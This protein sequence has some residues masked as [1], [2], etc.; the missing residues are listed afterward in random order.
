M[1]LT[2][3]PKNFEGSWIW[4]SD[5]SNKC[6]L[7]YEFYLKQI[8]M[9][10]DFWFA[11]GEFAHIYVNGMHL[12]YGPHAGN[13]DLYSINY[14][15]ITFL[16]QSGRNNITVLASAPDLSLYSRPKMP[17]GFWAQIL[18]DENEHF[19]T[20][21]DWKAGPAE[22]I[23]D[24]APR[25]SSGALP[26]QSF[27][28]RAHN[29]QEFFSGKSDINHQAQ[30]L[31]K[32]EATQFNPFSQNLR[33][34]SST[35]FP[36]IRALGLYDQVLPSMH[37]D[38]S[39]VYTKPGAYVA[40]SY[41]FIEEEV[42]TEILTFSDSA[43]KIFVNGFLINE[44]GTQ[45]FINDA[46]PS[47]HQEMSSMERGDLHPM[48][49]ATLKQ[50]WNSLRILSYCD[51]HSQ[52]LA[53][54]F[55][56]LSLGEAIPHIQRD[57]NSDRGHLLAGPL[58]IPFTNL[59]GSLN[60]N[61]LDFTPAPLNSFS[62]IS[63]FLQACTYKAES[64]IEDGS[65]TITL[66]PNQYLCYDLE[67]IHSGCVKLSIDTPQDSDIF[68]VFA[69]SFNDG[70]PRS[71]H[72]LHGRRAVHVKLKAGRNNWEDFFPVGLRYVFIL[73]AANFDINI[74]DVQLLA[75]QKAES[76]GT[77]FEGPDTNVNEIWKR[78]LSTLNSCSEYSYMDSPTGR[79]AQFLRDS[80]LQSIYSMTATGQYEQARTS[81]IE[82]SRGQYETGELPSVYPSSYI[83][84]VGESSMYWI[85]WLQ[86]YLLHTN[87]TETAEILLPTLKEIV[88]Y[89]SFFENKDKLLTGSVAILSSQIPDDAPM[90]PNTVFTSFN[91]IYLRML[92]ASSWIYSFLELEEDQEKA[93]EKM[94]L[95][96][97]NLRSLCWDQDKHLFSDWNSDGQLSQNYSAE[98]NFLAMNA[99]IIPSSSINDFL[100]QATIQEAPF[101][102]LEFL[103]DKS[104][105]LFDIV[106]QAATNINLR[107]WAYDLIKYYW[108]SM[109]DKE[110]ST[111][112]EFYDPDLDFSKE[113]TSLC[114]AIGSGPAQFFINE[115][116]GIRPAAPGYE[117]IYFNPLIDK[118]D[119]ARARI[120]TIHGHIK[121]E[122][123]KNPEGGIDVTIESAYPVD[124]IPQ[125]KQEIANNSSFHLSDN[126]S[127]IGRN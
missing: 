43:F 126:I 42:K 70:I 98:C 110:L 7:S 67:Q 127:I 68:L 76:T 97:K 121:V 85:M 118:Q 61:L 1:K 14:L 13:G 9:S 57:E 18:I 5:A 38:F 8:P 29:L 112:P 45:T 62:D 72:P 71:L 54:N 124:M 74:N 17:K 3:Y 81:L 73:S 19:A 104:P 22:H 44:Q 91:C 26:V 94:L 15:D 6:V 100:V 63:I 24:A 75:L 51:Q 55:I 77:K 103:H 65:K 53:L 93:Q 21:P 86:Q 2:P 95:I 122:W 105:Y 108:G 4:E 28:L 32:A 30:L 50:G 99:G 87:D 47:W 64:F 23:V 11:A 48:C 106:T 52:R 20:G 41:F 10:A 119:W 49:A 31:H 102:K 101:L 27:D 80:A 82:F 60:F 96:S 90:S 109:V 69:E 34:S 114:H 111:W 56:S 66:A 120:K 46:D 33:E 116:A 78:S 113:N 79:R 40:T 89:Y 92:S 37:I 35:P 84:T 16:L 59:A 25:R 83:Y 39:S 125:L 88:N 58:H 115:V 123:L 107:S 117:Q 36:K 12:T